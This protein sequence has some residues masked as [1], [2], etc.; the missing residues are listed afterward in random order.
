[1]KNKNQASCPPP[2]SLITKQNSVK[3]DT[4][5]INITLFQSH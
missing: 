1:L 3:L 2:S 4:V 5:F